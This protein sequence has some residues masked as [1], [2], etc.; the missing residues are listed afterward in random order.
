M[1]NKPGS[2]SE[3]FFSYIFS[4]EKKNKLSSLLEKLGDQNICSF[5]LRGMILGGQPLK[6]LTKYKTN[7]TTR[8]VKAGIRPGKR[9]TFKEKLFF[10]PARKL[11]CSKYNLYCSKFLHSS[12]EIAHS[13]FHSPG[14]RHDI[15][16]RTESAISSRNQ[17]FLGLHV[18]I[19]ADIH[20][21][22]GFIGP[23]DQC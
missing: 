21:L 4:A 12:Q 14:F 9:G 6:V 11:L 18:D 13:Q 22:F 7:R 19:Q 15:S 10:R 3:V 1:I 23:A 20:C 16:S 2:I 17:F 5:R 8:R